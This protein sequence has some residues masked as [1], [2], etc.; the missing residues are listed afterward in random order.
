LAATNGGTGL[1]SLGT[2]IATFLGTPSSA[3][4]AASLTDETGTGSAVF[5]TSPTLVTPILG[6][7]QSAT[8]TNATGLPLTTGV[9]GTLSAS[10]GG[11]GASTLA[12]NNVLLGNGTSALQVVAPGSSGNVLTSNGSSW[13]SAALGG[14]SFVFLSSV[15]ASGAATVSS[16]NF[17]NSSY[18]SYLIVLSEIVVTGG[19]LYCRIAKSGSAITT[20]N[21]NYA[22]TYIDVAASSIVRSGSSEAQIRMTNSA[23]TFN[24]SISFNIADS[25]SSAPVICF[26]ISSHN[27]NQTGGGSLNLTGAASGFQ[28]YNNGGTIDSGYMRIYGI[29]NS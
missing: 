9:T 7:P 22:F 4:L 29:K 10:N 5:A 26:N 27:T 15:A 23:G 18:S 3:N 21:Y 14:S 13:T 8:L 17:A 24:G 20:S 28:L 2:G 1:T 11:T 19:Q 25:G 12:A 6:T 16:L